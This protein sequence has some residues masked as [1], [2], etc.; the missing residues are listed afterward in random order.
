MLISCFVTKDF[1]CLKLGKECAKLVNSQKKG[2]VFGQM[3]TYLN[4]GPKV[5]AL[6]AATPPKAQ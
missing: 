1:H 3:E 5:L 4:S 2:L 6:C